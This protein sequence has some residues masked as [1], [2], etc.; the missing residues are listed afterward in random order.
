MIIYYTKEGQSL[1]DLCHEVQLENPEYLRDYHHQ[2]CS[3][4]ERFKDDLTPGM[5]LYIPSS[6]EILE[7]NKKIRDNNQSFYDFPANGR[8]PFDFKHWEG[9][10]QITQTTYSDDTILAK[11]ENKVRLDLEGTK[12]R[13]YHFLFSAFDFK[14]NEDASDTKVDT[15]AK[16][17][18]E[19]I[20]PIQYIIDTDGK[21]IDIVVTKKTEDILSELD[22]IKN[23]FPDQYSSD[24]IQKMKSIVESPEIILQKFKNTLFNSFMFGTFYRTQLGNWVTSNVYYDFCPWIFDAQSIQ[25]EFQNIL[26]SKDIVDDKRVKIQQKGIS[27][28]SRN[29]EYLHFTDS[30]FDEKTDIG[31]K[32]IDCEHLAEYLFNRENLSLYKIEARFQYFGHENTRREDFLLE[33]ITDNY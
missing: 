21:L 15:L 1:V 6:R 4:S 5:K 33:R 13:Y 11:Y 8:F 20:Y 7:I 26:L 30:K 23:F 28:D 31:K 29:L 17:C 2:N 14:K 19:T 24:Y 12:N 27:I 16:M 9:N 3:L 22:S 25:F 32:P 10:Y 18:M